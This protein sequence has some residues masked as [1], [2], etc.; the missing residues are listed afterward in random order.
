LSHSSVHP[1]PIH[2]LPH[3]IAQVAETCQL[4]LQRIERERAG[5][6]EAP[7]DGPSPY[8]SVDP[9]QAAPADTPMQQV[10]MRLPSLRFE[11]GTSRRARAVWSQQLL[12]FLQSLRFSKTLP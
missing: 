11:R 1:T 6:A 9:M 3:C 2:A 5:S 4:A 8:L 10:R 12:A 7:G